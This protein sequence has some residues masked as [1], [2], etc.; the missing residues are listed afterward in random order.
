MYKCSGSSDERVLTLR[1]E[2]QPASKHQGAYMLL[3]L[4]SPYSELFTCV[5][6]F[7]VMLSKSLKHMPRVL[8][9][10]LIVLVVG[11]TAYNNIREKARSLSLTTDFTEPTT[12]LNSAYCILPK[13]I[14]EEKV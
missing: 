5:L 7:S 11:W 13:A 10:Y 4:R 1:Q 9:D 12:N 3:S 14:S 2:Q 6:Y 8:F